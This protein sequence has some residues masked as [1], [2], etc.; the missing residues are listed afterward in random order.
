MTQI[1]KW[2]VIDTEY[3][4]RRPWLTARKD[5]VILPDG[6]VMD[7]YYVLEYPT[8][9]NVIAITKDGR[10]VMVEQYRHGLRDVF[11]ELCAG[12][13]EDNETPIDAAKRELR[14][15]TG[16]TGGQWRL[17][18]KLSQNPSACTNYTYCFLAEGVE[19][20]D[21]QHLDATEDIAVR[22]LAEREVIDLL[23][24]DK[25]KQ[26]LMAA[27]LWHYFADKFV[28]AK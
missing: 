15:E 4:I 14:E 1:K 17:L 12:V 5:T 2:R 20:T 8:W 21:S 9:I 28:A 22:L 3:L 27:P 13:V 7:D 11:T 24:E 18:N 6:K 19:K 25:I 16:Y 26:S 23:K 10:F